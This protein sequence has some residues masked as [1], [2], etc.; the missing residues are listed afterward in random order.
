MEI[1]FRS[2]IDM[3]QCPCTDGERCKEI[4]LDRSVRRIGEGEY[5]KKSEYEGVWYKETFWCY[6]CGQ[7]VKEQEGILS[8]AEAEARGW[9]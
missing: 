9:L 2:E 7:I 3:D 4:K 6:Q 8:K 5:H 1:K